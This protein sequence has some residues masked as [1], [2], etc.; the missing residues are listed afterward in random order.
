MKYDVVVIGAG[1]AGSTAAKCLAENGIKVLLLDKSE[2]PRDKPCGGG[3]PTRVLKRF[4]Y[5][6]PLIDSISFGSSTYSSSHRYRFDLIRE[7]PLL[8]NVIRKDFDY[9]L[10]N[11]Q[12]QY[13]LEEKQSLM[14]QSN[15]IMQS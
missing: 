2:F 1:P 7:K 13:F 3:L 14:C 4:Q 12:V 5:I 9:G 10:V 6:E 15:K 8:L 11:L